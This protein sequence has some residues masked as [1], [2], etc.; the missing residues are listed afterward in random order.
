M[1]EHI[2]DLVTYQQA[3]MLLRQW[4]HDYNLENVQV[5][6]WRYAQAPNG[7]MVL[8]YVER[9]PIHIPITRTTNSDTGGY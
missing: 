4:S 9:T 5:T 1:K 7:F 3:Q 8:L 2:I 6:P